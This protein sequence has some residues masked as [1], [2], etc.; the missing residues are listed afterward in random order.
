M[1]LGTALLGTL[2][3]LW[4]QRTRSRRQARAWEEKYD[5]LRKDGRHGDMNSVQGQRPELGGWRP[6]ELDGGIVSEAASR[7][8]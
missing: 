7:M 4:G 1:P 8:K 6:N 3:L 2:I 5:E